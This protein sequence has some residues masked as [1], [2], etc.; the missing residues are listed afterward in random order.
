MFANNKLLFL[1]L[2]LLLVSPAFAGSV[3][4]PNTFQSGEQAVAQEVNDNFTALET[5]VND[6]DAR[7]AALETLVANLQTALTT[8]NTTI[9][10]LEDELAILQTNSVLDLDGYLSLTTDTNDIPTATFS[11]VNVNINNGQGATASANGSGNL[12]V[13]YNEVKTFG[14]FVCSDGQYDNEQACVAG[15]AVWDRNHRS[16]SH[17]IVAGARNSYSSYGGLVV[18]D[19]NAITAR[20]TSVSGG[21]G[22]VARVQ[23]S[24][25]SGGTNNVAAGTGASVSGGFS[26]TADGERSSVSGGLSNTASGPNSSISGGAGRNIDSDDSAWWRAGPFYTDNLSPRADSTIVIGAP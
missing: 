14:T 4:V 25:V 12:I 17:N 20:F 8:A 5:A 26:N 2:S 1:T 11:A 19:T 9:A 15:G 3:D 7:I 21:A 23:A 24:S 10:N 16:G 22:N 13:G 6:N 18:G